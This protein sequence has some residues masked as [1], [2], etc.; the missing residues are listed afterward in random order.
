MQ[1]RRAIL[2]SFVFLFVLSP[3]VFLT[4]EVHSAS[5]W[6]VV[7]DAGHGGKDPGAQ[8]FSGTFEKNINLE[9]ARIV[10]ILSLTDSEIEVVLT[11][12]DDVFIPLDERINIAERINADLYVSIHSNGHDSAQPHGFE[13]VVHERRSRNY[14]S[15]MDLARVLQEVIVADLQSE[16]MR[17]RGIKQRALYTSWATMPA[18]IVETGFVSNPA[19]EARLTSIWYQLDL[20]RSILDGLKSYLK[21]H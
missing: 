20:G 15:S 5:R 6:V 18:V 8:G 4:S 1:N 21:T 10:R 16:G 19:D 2:L 7:I 11:R 14:S 3:L 12:Y 17:D 13:V 9:I